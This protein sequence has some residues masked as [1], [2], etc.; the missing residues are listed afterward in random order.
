MLRYVLESTAVLADHVYSLQTRGFYMTY[1]YVGC[2]KTILK[3]LAYNNKVLC[4]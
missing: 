1:Y 4:L 3:I 2:E